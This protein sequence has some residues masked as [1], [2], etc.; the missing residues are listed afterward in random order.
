MWLRTG[1]DRYVYAYIDRTF[2]DG[3]RLVLLMG[4]QNWEIGLQG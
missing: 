2:L 1:N 3:Y 4:E